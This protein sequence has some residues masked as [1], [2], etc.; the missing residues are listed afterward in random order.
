MSLF[1]FETEGDEEEDLDPRSFC[2]A[3]WQEL[4]VGVQKNQVRKQR[5]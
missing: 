5:W 2:F 3:P 1:T 4:L